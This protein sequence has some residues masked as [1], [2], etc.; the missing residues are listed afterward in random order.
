MSKRED[1]VLLE[2]IRGSI[3]RIYE[4]T[5]GLS[6]EG[7]TNDLKTQDAVV[8]NL[9]IIGEA[10]KQSHIKRDCFAS[11]AMTLTW[12]LMREN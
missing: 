5:R 9:E 10:T 12:K 1:V 11:L 6:Y 8:R 7:F 3:K 2:D 4:Y